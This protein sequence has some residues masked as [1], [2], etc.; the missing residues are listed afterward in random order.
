MSQVLFHDRV[1][2]SQIARYWNNNAFKKYKAIRAQLPHTGGGDPDAARQDADEPAATSATSARQRASDV[3][4]TTVGKLSA[5]S[6][7]AFYNSALYPLIDAVYACICTPLNCDTHLGFTILH[8]PTLPLSART[9]STHPT[10]SSTPVLPK[11]VA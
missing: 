3:T 4:F 8:T 7:L 1:S 11:S 9:R 2:A 5:D 6:L 10:P